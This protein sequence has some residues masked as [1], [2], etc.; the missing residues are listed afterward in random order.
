MVQRTPLAIAA[1]LALALPAAAADP[2]TVPAAFAPSFFVHVGASGL[3]TDEDATVRANGLTVP[4]GSALIQDRATVAVE[5]GW[6]VTPEI[7]LA[8]TGG[9]PMLTAIKGAGSLASVGTA[10]KALNG[11]AVA[12]V[13]VHPG[14]WGPV[15]PYLGLG[16]AYLHVFDNRD[17]A[18]SDFAVRDH[19]GFVLQAGTDLMLDQHWGVF[20]DLKETWLDT[21]SRGFLGPVRVDTDMDMRTTAVFSG[22]TYRF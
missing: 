1:W 19:W 21:T 12:T 2:V 9:I 14:G 18:L 7:A 3:F 8:V 22:I 20:V 13:Q 17:G 16:A 5:A 15:Q 6:Y 4:G 10:G 11:P